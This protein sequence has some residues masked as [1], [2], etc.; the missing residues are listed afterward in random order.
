MRVIAMSI[1]LR[2]PLGPQPAGAR[3]LHRHAQHQ[4]HRLLAAGQ[5]RHPPRPDAHV[6]ADVP[7]SP[8]RPSSPHPRRHLRGRVRD[9]RRLPHRVLRYALRPVLRRRARNTLAISAFFATFFLGGWWLWGLDEW[10]PR[11]DHPA[12]QDRHGVF[13]LH[14]AARHPAPS[15]ARPAD[16]V[17]LEVPRPRRARP[18]R[19]RATQRTLLIRGG[20]GTPP[21]RCPSSASSTGS[22]PASRSSSSARRRAHRRS[23]CPPGRSWRA[24]G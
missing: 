10:I 2:D 12:R 13:R 6:G 22:S 19:R 8:P 1:S 17:L 23:V 24:A 3:L 4:R 18:H 14:L 7:S 9:R 11:L 20:L 5:R 16:V 21:S 15:A